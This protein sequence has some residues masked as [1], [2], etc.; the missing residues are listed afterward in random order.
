MSDNTGG[1]FQNDASRPSRPRNA[2]RSNASLVRQS[3]ASADICSFSVRS[4]C[5][6]KKRGV[7]ADICSSPRVRPASVRSVRPRSVARTVTA[8][9]VQVASPTR[10]T[11]VAGCTV[12]RRPPRVE[13]S[14]CF[15]GVCHGG[16]PR[17]FFDELCRRCFTSFSR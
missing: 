14:L 17:G 8:P 2:R 3:G 12:A 7:S 6:Q 10:P 1:T 13:S 11:D 15:D 16:R 9:D 4:A 5:G